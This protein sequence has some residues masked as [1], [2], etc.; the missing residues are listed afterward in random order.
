MNTAGNT[1]TRSRLLDQ[2][3]T[4]LMRPGTTRRTRALLGVT[5]GLVLTVTACGD[6][7]VGKGGPGEWP[8]LAPPAPTSLTTEPTHSPDSQERALTGNCRAGDPLAVGRSAV[9]AGV[10]H[11]YLRVD[12]H[13]CT[14]EP[15]SLDRPTVTGVSSTGTMKRLRLTPTPVANRDEAPFTLNPGETASAGLEW[16]A[17]PPEGRL[18]ELRL[19][20]ATGDIPTSVLFDVLEMAPTSHLDYYPWVSDPDDV[21]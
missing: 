10:G 2:W 19:S 11:R 18:Q 16:L 12:V 20:A 3:A 7:S 15:I 13:N 21:F 4:A 5:L 14:S 8:D 1:A 6:R 9:D 17:E